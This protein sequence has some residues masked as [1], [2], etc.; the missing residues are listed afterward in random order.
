MNVLF[1]S[2]YHFNTETFGPYLELMQEH[3]DKGDTIIFLSC[4]GELSSCQTNP[5]KSKL[6]CNTCISTRKNAV[7]CLT[8]PI[9][10][11]TLE[12][13]LPLSKVDTQQHLLDNS[14]IANFKNCTYESFDI[15]MAVFSSVVSVFRDPTPDLIKN[16]DL[17]EKQW[18]SA[19]WV[20]EAVKQLITTQAIDRVYVFNARFATLRACLRASEHLSKDCFVL[21]ESNDREHYAIY[22]NAMPHSI[23]YIEGL[24]EDYWEK[25]DPNKSE[26]AL[27]YY[28]NRNQGKDSRFGHF[29]AQQLKDK[30]PEQWDEGKQNIVIYISSEDEFVAIGKEW[31]NNLYKTQVDAIQKISDA[32]VSNEDFVFYIRVH[33]NLLGILNDSIYSLY[34]ITNKNVKIIPAD[35]PISTYSLMFNATKIISFGSS[36]GIEAAAI[37]KISILAGKSFYMNLGST[38]NPKSHD[39]LIELLL[40]NDLPIKSTEGALKYAYYLINSGINYQHFKRKDTF[41]AY[42]NGKIYGPNFIYLTIRKIGRIIRLQKAKKLKAKNIELTKHLVRNEEIR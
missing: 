34:S 38:Y 42:L 31:E 19:V 5:F 1:Y 20:Y 21:E 11:Y 40:R 9:I 14:S 12:D 36:V 2:T 23:G 39:E 33:P 28:N 15:G 7:A 32:F 18:T 37:G 41:Q 4:T 13:I 22:E 30:L 10:E 35:S 24:I 8:K 3:I 25:G 27:N 16:C 17:V 26:V 6:V 29:T